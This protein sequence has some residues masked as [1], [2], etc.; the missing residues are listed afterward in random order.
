MR[1]A[2]ASD[3]PAL[4]AWFTH[5]TPAEALEL[6]ATA[7]GIGLFASLGFR[8]RTHPTLRLGLSAPTDTFR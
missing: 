4:V 5:H 2:D 7:D 3:A 1:R 8:E 6:S